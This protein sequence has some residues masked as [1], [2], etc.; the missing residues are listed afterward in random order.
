[1]TERVIVITTSFP[2]APDDAAGHFVRSDARRRVALAEDV[3]VVC[4]SARAL[5]FDGELRV[6]GVGGEALFAW[7][8]AWARARERPTRLAHAPAF[9]L[10]ARSLVRE[11]SRGRPS[12]VVAHWALP[13]AWPIATAHAGPLEIVSHGADVRLLLRLPHPAR[14]ALV[15]RLL[16]ADTTWSFVSQALREQLIA[17]LD[18]S[19]G[20][21][22]AELSRVEPAPIEVPARDEL[23]TLASR[24]GLEPGRYVVWVG[25]DVPSKRLELA[26]DACELAGVPLAIVGAARRVGSARVRSLGALPRL[27]ALSMIAR[28]RVLLCTSA[29]EGA[30]T[31]VREARA[32]GVPVV[33][34]D[35]GDLRRW[36]EL[37]PGI[38]LVAPEASAIAEALASLSDT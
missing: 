27:E 32:L 34:C 24:F 8:G 15:K 31:V 9:A 7:P 10:R 17:G 19:L 2:E 37:D 35:V 11:L 23:P 6:H 12:R 38:T 28:A 4:P 16:G 14:A 30:P 26:L 33:A 5:R 21:R 29:V 13:S 18:P 1:M 22:L 3:H 36:A 20:A 25:R